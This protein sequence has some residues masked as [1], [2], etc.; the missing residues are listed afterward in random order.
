MVH[1][2][3]CT[4]K[5]SQHS[6]SSIK[7]NYKRLVSNFKNYNTDNDFGDTEEQSEYFLQFIELYYILPN[8]K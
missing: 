7:R 1:L 5:R 6:K 4:K 2:R 3:E 8:T